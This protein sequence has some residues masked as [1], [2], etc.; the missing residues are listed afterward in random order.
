MI[1]EIRCSDISEITSAGSLLPKSEITPN[2][3]LAV[4]NCSLLLLF[5]TFVAVGCNSGKVSAPDVIKP[6]TFVVDSTDKFP[7]ITD[8]ALLTLVQKQTFKYFWD[9]AHPVSGLARERNTSGDIVTS[10]GSGFGI[11]TIPVAIERGFITRTEGLQ[12]MQKITGFLKTNTQKFHGA[13]P[14]WINGNTGAVVPFSTK[15]DGADL[16]ETSYLIQGLLTARQYF[17]GTDAAETGLR[18]NI[19]T[20]WQGVEWDWFRKNK[21]NVLYWHWSPTNNWD[22]NL[23]IKGWNECLITYALAASSP[24]HPIPKIVYDNGWT[25]NGSFVNGKDYYGI[26]LP[27]GDAYGG[28]LFFSQYSFLGLNP[29]LLIDKYTNYFN[30]NRSHALIN[31]NY[32]KNNP[33]KYYGYSDQCWGLTASDIPDGY[34][35]SSPT[36]DQGVIA[37]TAALSS[38]PY[39]PVESMKALKFFYYKLGDK[40]WGEYGFYDA[41]ALKQPWFASSYL[42]IDQGPIIIMIENH[43]SQLLWNLFMSCPEIQTGLKNLDFQSS[44]L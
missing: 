13:F 33:L 15:D 12:R 2:I 11:M 4:K 29:K 25:S 36:N 28:P 39:T 6:S 37:P 18:N 1:K 17:N 26:T 35:A 40:I 44:G 19:N 20:I 38:F 9:F 31:Y 3:S 42:A 32:C 30:Q 8:E 10:G 43:R 14:H 7:A 41:F 24:T 22:M 34:T 23:P 5:L 16:V 21:E 27:L